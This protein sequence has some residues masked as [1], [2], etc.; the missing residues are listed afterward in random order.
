MPLPALNGTDFLVINMV[1]DWTT[2]DKKP[3]SVFNA[4]VLYSDPTRG[5]YRE[6]I[7]DCA[8]VDLT[9]VERCLYQ[10]IDTTTQSK[11]VLTGGYLKFVIWARHNG[12]WSW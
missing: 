9:V 3:S 12:V 6:L 5:I 4:V 7:K 11:G 10:R 2:L 1:R 8:K